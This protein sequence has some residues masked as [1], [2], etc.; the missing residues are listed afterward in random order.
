MLREGLQLNWSVRKIQIAPWW[1]Y[2][3][4]KLQSALAFR[5]YKAALSPLKW[6][7]WAKRGNKPDIIDAHANKVDWD[8]L[9][10]DGDVVQRHHSPRRVL[11][12]P[13]SRRCPRCYAEVKKV[14]RVRRRV[15]T[16][17]G[18]K[19]VIINSTYDSLALEDAFN[20][21][22]KIHTFAPAST[23]LATIS[24]SSSDST[25]LE[26]S[27]SFIIFPLDITSTRLQ[28]SKISWASSLTM[29]IPI[30]WRAKSRIISWIVCLEP[31][32]IPMVGPSRINSLGSVANHLAM[33]TRCCFPRALAG[34]LGVGV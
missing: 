28:L 29:T 31:I 11:R 7:R 14:S 17:K 21:L 12:R 25:V 20:A 1:G 4:P 19:D 13:Q 15:I 9:A 24:S 34:F 26:S 10:N 33:T 30:P 16:N 5:S 18:W 6:Y 27:N 3:Y 2:S 23:R 22:F 8:I 32:S